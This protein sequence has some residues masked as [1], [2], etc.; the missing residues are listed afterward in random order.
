M[1]SVSCEH[2]RGHKVAI[3]IEMALDVGRDERAEWHYHESPGTR[4]VE[5][6]S[7]QLGAQTQPFVGLVDLGVDEGDPPVAKAVLRVAN[8][9]AVHPKLVTLLGWVVADLDVHFPSFE[10]DCF[11]TTT[12]AKNSMRQ[13]ISA[14]PIIEGGTSPS[15]AVLDNVPTLANFATRRITHLTGLTRWHVEEMD[16]L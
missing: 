5:R 3:L 12:M 6:H 1:V 14:T 16:R 11:S 7:G 2:L 10:R 13:D 9:L 15:P 4:I 8:P